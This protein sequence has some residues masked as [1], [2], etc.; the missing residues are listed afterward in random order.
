MSKVQAKALPTPDE[1][2]DLYDARDA[3][4]ETWRNYCD[5]HEISWYKWVRGQKH[6]IDFFRAEI[7]AV[8]ARFD[9]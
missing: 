6:V 2:N 1:L 3:A 8:F 9:E 5:K 7:D 4:T